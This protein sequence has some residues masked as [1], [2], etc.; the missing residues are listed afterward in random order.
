MQVYRPF[1][2]LK[3]FEKAKTFS[4]LLK[5]YFVDQHQTFADFPWDKFNPKDLFDRYTKLDGEKQKR[6]HQQLGMVNDLA[7]P[8]AM[9]YLTKK[10]RE[11]DIDTADKTPYELA[12]LFYL[13]K[14]IDFY[15]SHEFFNIEQNKGYS[16]FIG[17]NKKQ[18][19]PFESIM[20]V[21][22]EAIKGELKEQDRG[23][24][25]IKYC[26]EPGENSRKAYLIYYEDYKRQER[27]IK[28]DDLSYEDGRPVYEAVLIYSD[29][30]QLKMKARNKP[31]RDVCKDTFAR[32]VLGDADFFNHPDA[33]KTYKLDKFCTLPL[34]YEAKPEYGIE[35]VKET[36]IKVTKNGSGETIELHSEK[37]L[38]GLLKT[39]NINLNQVEITQI[40]LKI[41]FSEGG[42]SSRRTIWMSQSNHSN[43]CDSD[44][45]RII[46]ACLK[47]WKIANR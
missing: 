20:P 12:L 13:E 29:D 16:D 24:L 41:K 18:P 27:K 36:G 28:N 7:I 14:P 33:E 5:R 8:K 44:A 19:K 22:R 26:E 1:Y 45:D 30:K 40:F 15:N 17:K 34:E 25:V 43:I 11:L 37:D 21:W 38:K 23:N 42:R 31:I 47:D 35:S 46:G 10:A 2:S 6:F 32:I 3:F 4:P 39:H 9:P